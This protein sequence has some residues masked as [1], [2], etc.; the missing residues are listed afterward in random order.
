MEG[1]EGGAEQ[2]EAFI[3]L[4]SRESPLAE[5]STHVRMAETRDEFEDPLHSLLVR[6][7]CHVIPLI[8][9]CYPRLL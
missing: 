1:V 2:A 4:L 6:E 9:G 5:R 3:R 7:P 8:A